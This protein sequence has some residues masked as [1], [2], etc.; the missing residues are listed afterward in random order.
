MTT[1]WMDPVE[2]RASGAFIAEQALR[3]QET[4]TGTRSTCSCEVPR[5]M[6]GWLDAE[7]LALTEDAL[8]VAVSYL[9]E[10][11]DIAQRANLI[12]ADQTLA[13]SQSALLPPGTAMT[14]AVLSGAYVGG[15][16]I[17]GTPSGSSVFAPTTWASAPAYGSGWNPLSTGL[18]SS[19]FGGPSFIDVAFNS[20]DGISTMLAP[21]GL[22]FSDGQWEDSAGRR[23]S[24]PAT[25][26]EDPVTG[27][28]DF[29]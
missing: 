24:S 19:S 1:I 10:V 27:E 15:M 26:Y 21:K 4:V 2:L 5:S 20:N 29:G 22:S 12:A 18:G 25:A 17:D 16:V 9:T 14:S 6:I 28:L 13:A 8:R 23:S 3:I 11:V 7:L